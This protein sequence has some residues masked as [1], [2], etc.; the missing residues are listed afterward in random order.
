MI[1]KT[2]TF[3]NALD[4]E[5]TRDLYFGLTKAEY[6]ELEAD[7]FEDG[8][9][10]GKLELVQRQDNPKLIMSTFKEIIGRSYGERRGEDFV[11]TPDIKAAFLASD[12]YSEILFGLI[13]GD[14]DPGA[15]I[16]G[17]LPRGGNA[18]GSVKS[19]SQQAREASEARMTGFQKKQA[20]QQRFEPAPE[21]NTADPVLQD[22]PEWVAKQRDE[23]LDDLTADFDRLHREDQERRQANETP[24]ERDAREFAEFQAMKRERGQ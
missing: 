2:I 5:V 20:P 12:A 14:D 18:D 4:N 10:E 13:Q 9:I 3:V 21:L 1:K 23:K 7:W 22:D 11:K 15:F 16:R 24:A 8:G 19:Q 6:L 17:I